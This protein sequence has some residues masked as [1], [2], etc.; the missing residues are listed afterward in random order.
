MG[1]HGEDVDND[2]VIVNCIDKTMLAIDTPGPQA[3]KRKPQ[4]FRLADASVGMLGYVGKQLFDAIHNFHITALDKGVIMR[5]CCLGEDYL[6]HVMRSK[7]SSIVS[8][9]C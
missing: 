1:M 6:V 5:Y 3:S 2:T 8:P 4:G 9:S 7:S